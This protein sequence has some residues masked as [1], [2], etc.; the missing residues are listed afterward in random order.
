MSPFD[1]SHRHWHVRLYAALGAQADMINFYEPAIPDLH[2]YE[3]RAATFDLP[4]LMDDRNDGIPL[5][6]GLQSPLMESFHYHP[7]GL[8]RSRSRR[9]VLRRRLVRGQNV[10][11][12]LAQNVCSRESRW[13]RQSR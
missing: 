12:I 9:R 10:G 1:P 4:S 5:I 13:R 2:F 3:T 6:V 11:G 8:M 7:R